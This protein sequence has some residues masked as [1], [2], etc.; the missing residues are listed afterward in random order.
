MFYRRI[1]KLED[2]DISV[3]ASMPLRD[4]DSESRDRRNN[5]HKVIE[6]VVSESDEE[7][8]RGLSRIALVS[9]RKRTKV[10]ASVGA[11]HHDEHIEDNE[12]IFSEQNKSKSKPNI[13]SPFTYN[14]SLYID[15]YENEYVEVDGI[16]CVIPPRSR[17][18]LPFRMYQI[19]DTLGSLPS[20]C[21]NGLP[22]FWANY[23]SAGPRRS[24]LLRA[25]GPGMRSRSGCTT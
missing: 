2:E 10:A 6:E 14:R 12:V 15:Q 21:R 24:H 20:G 8:Y 16:I 11:D 5:K 25:R 4:S 7:N 3:A 17:P 9:R 23:A 18:K 22:G 19:H 13:E 1:I